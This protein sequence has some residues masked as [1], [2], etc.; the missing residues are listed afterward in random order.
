MKDTKITKGESG[1]RRCETGDRGVDGVRELVDAGF[2][3]GGG[4]DRLFEVG[5]FSA[6]GGE[7]GGVLHGDRFEFLDALCQ[8]GDGG[9]HGGGFREE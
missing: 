6:G 9:F 4:V 8:S 3:G 1:G 5:D 7:V 2:V